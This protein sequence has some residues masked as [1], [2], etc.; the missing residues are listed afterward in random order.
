[1]NCP[2]C[3]GST[4]VADRR[5]VRRRREC[6]SCGHRFSTIEMLASD[7]PKKVAESIRAAEPAPK[8]KAEKKVAPKRTNSVSTVAIKRNAD[9]RR[10]IE[11]MRERKSLRD[12]FDYLDPDYD[13]LPERW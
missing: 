2:K 7:V 1:M 3:N 9:A 12:D 11:E 5:G 4:K 6:L 10:K 13:Y 8:P